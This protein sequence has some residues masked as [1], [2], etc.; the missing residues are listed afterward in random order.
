MQVEWCNGSARGVGSWRS[1]VSIR[2]D[3]IC[4]D[5]EYCRGNYIGTYIG[6]SI[7]TYMGAYMGA[8]IRSKVH[9][10]VPKIELRYLFGNLNSGTF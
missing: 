8:Q 3:C 2:G 5:G 7:G 1:W 4:G 6:T 10:W 9:I